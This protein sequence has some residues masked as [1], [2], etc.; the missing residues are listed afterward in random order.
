MSHDETRVVAGDWAG[1]IRVFDINDGKRVSN[2]AANP[3]V[4]IPAG[5]L[6]GLP[7]GLQVIG[8]HHSEQ[9]LLELAAIAEAERPWPLVAP[10]SPL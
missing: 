8:K 2:L 4:S 7:V 3:A 1:E 5:N 6:D 9:L 10:G